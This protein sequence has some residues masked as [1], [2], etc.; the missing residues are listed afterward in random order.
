MSPSSLRSPGLIVAPV[1]LGLAL[2]ALLLLA[3]GSPAPN[4]S[5]DPSGAQDPVPGSA[6]MRARINPE[7]GGLEVSAGLRDL[8][9]DPTTSQAL[10]RDTEGLIPVY[11]PDGSVSVDLQGRF[12]SVS[13]ARLDEKGRVIYCPEGAEAPSPP[14][15]GSGETTAQGRPV[16]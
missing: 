16:R 1:L 6:A 10:R 13:V 8:T 11:H 9:L 3:P 5:L 12:Q 14:L 15:E 7:T 2:I 4:A